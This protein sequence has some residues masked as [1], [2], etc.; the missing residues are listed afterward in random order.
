MEA[1]S[2]PKVQMYSALFKKVV[3]T[4]TIVR[5]IGKLED[6]KEIEQA[7]KFLLCQLVELQKLTEELPIVQEAK[8]DRISAA[9]SSIKWPSKHA[10]P[11]WM[12]MPKEL[13]EKLGLEDAMLANDSGETANTPAQPDLES[14]KEEF[15]EIFWENMLRQ[16]DSNP[17][18]VSLSRV[19]QDITV[20]TLGYPCL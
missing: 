16:M 5:N 6:H 13:Q 8:K 19:F 15:G 10:N 9:A 12:V 4:N 1:Q 3:I 20:L 18:L 7:A 17:A 14:M 11:K 2:D